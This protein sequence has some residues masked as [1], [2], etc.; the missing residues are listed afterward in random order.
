MKL[1]QHEQ[2]ELLYALQYNHDTRN[3]PADPIKFYKQIIEWEENSAIFLNE[4]CGYCN[5]KMI[6]IGS[7][8]VHACK[9]DLINT[10]KILD[11]NKQLKEINKHL[12]TKCN[13]I[14]TRELKDNNKLREYNT[15]MFQQLEKIK[16]GLEKGYYDKKSSVILMDILR[17]EPTDII[18]GGE[19]TS[20]TIENPGLSKKAN[21]YIFDDAPN[22]TIIPEDE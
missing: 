16:E 7:R 21:G 12:V 15:K 2:D 13:Q 3:F 10:D 9:H 6:V 20:V 17:D 4:K 1:A 5:E 14:T 22:I 11:E 18:K 19:I 8:H